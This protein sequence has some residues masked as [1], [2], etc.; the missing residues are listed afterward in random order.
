MKNRLRTY[1]I[2][3]SFTTLIARA[4]LSHISNPSWSFCI[5]QNSH[6]KSKREGKRPATLL[7]LASRRST[8]TRQ[9]ILVELSYVLRHACLFLEQRHRFY[10]SCLDTLMQHDSIKCSMTFSKIMCRYD[11]LRSSSERLAWSLIIKKDACWN[12]SSRVRLWQDWRTFFS[13]HDKLY[14]IHNF[15]RNSVTYYVPNQMLMT[16]RCFFVSKVIL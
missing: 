13:R 7:W 3:F 11:V 6:R 10:W 14:L 4:D 5:R 9:L 15:E 2:E 8:T 1:C 16:R 12:I